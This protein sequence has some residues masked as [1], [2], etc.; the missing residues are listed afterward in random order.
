MNWFQNILLLKCLKEMRNGD[1]RGDG[2]SSRSNQLFQEDPIM[3]E[4]E[5]VSF[6]LNKIQKLVEQMLT[7]VA[8]RC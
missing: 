8:G 7:D 2:T 4:E 6:T 3:L 5:M 1:Q